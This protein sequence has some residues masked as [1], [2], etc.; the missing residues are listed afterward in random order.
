MKRIASFLIAALMICTVIP[1]AVIPAAAEEEAQP[2]FYEFL[3]VGVGAYIDTGFKPNE[4]TKVVM[5]VMVRG[6]IEYWFGAW[7]IDYRHSAFALGNDSG[8]VYCGYGNQGG[9]EGSLVSPGRH[10]VELGGFCFKLDNANVRPFSSEH[11]SLNSTLYLFAQNRNGQV[12]LRGNEK[13]GIRFYSCQIFDAGLLVRDF[14]PATKVNEAGVL[15]VGVYD[16]ENEVFYAGKGD[17]A[18][19]VY[20]SATL[21]SGLPSG[22]QNEGVLLD[23]DGKI[24]VSKDTTI[25]ALPA[26]SGILIG[27]GKKVTIEVK[28]GVTL[29]VNG[30]NASGRYGGGAGI[31]VPASSTLEIIGNGTLNVKGGNAAVGA[32]GENGKGGTD[33]IQAL[34]FS[35]GQLYSGAGGNGGYG[36]GGAGAGIGGRGGFGGAG[37]AGAVGLTVDAKTSTACTNGI[38]GENGKNGIAGTKGGKITVADTL[39]GT[40][41]GGTTLSIPSQ[42]GYPGQRQASYYTGGTFWYCAC[43]GGGGGAGGNGFA[44]AGIGSGGAGAGGGAGGGSGLTT[45][46]DDLTNVNLVVGTGHGGEGGIGAVNGVNGY[47]HGL[48]VNT[49]DNVAG[50]GGKA[51]AAGGGKGDGDN[52]V[53]LDEATRKETQSLFLDV[54]AGAYIDTGYVPTEKTRIVFDAELNNEMAAVFGVI[55]NADKAQNYYVNSG[56]TTF[57]FGFGSNDA[58]W[59][60]ISILPGHHTIEF[61]DY[62]LKYG[63]SKDEHKASAFSLNGLS[64]YLFGIH[65]DD[66]VQTFEEQHIRCYSCK[67]YEGNKLVRDYIPATYEDRIVFF[68]QQN[69]MIYE[70]QG[71]IPFGIGRIVSPES[72]LPDG[73]TNKGVLIDF[74]GTITVSKNTTINAF[75]MQNGISIADGR[76]VTIE[77]KEGVTLTVKGGDGVDRIGAGAGIEVPENA[78]LTITG[79][80][81]LNATGGNAAA[82]GKGENGEA[83]RL[84]YFDPAHDGTSWLY[85]GAGGKGGNGGGGAGAGIGSKGGNGGLGGNGAAGVDRKETGFYIAYASGLNGENGKNGFTAK[86]Y[87][88]ITVHNSVKK[89]V[90]GGDA[91]KDASDGGNGGNKC[92]QPESTLW[93]WAFGGG[94]GGAGGNGYPAADIGTGGAG[95]GGGAGGGSG[96]IT[97]YNILTNNKPQGTGHGGKGGV[98]AV[99]GKPGADNGDDRD[100]EELVAGAGGEGGLAGGGLTTIGIWEAEQLTELAQAVAN[101]TDYAGVCFRLA[102]DITYNGQPIGS[103]GHPFKGIFDGDGYT[104]TVNISKTDTGAGLFAE[105]DGATIKNLEIKGTVSGKDCVGG[106]VGHAYGNTLIDNCHV[107]ASVTGTAVNIGGV[108]GMLFDS[109]VSNCRVD[110]TVEST[111]SKVGYAGGIVGWLHNNSK[112]VNCVKTGKTSGYKAVGGIVGGAS[113]GDSVI[114]NCTSIGNIKGDNDIGGIIGSI[115]D[116]I[117]TIRLYT[118]Y[119]DCLLDSTHARG[120]ICGYNHN[121][122]DEKV[123]GQPNTLTVEGAQLYYFK[124]KSSYDYTGQ[125]PPPSKPLTTDNVSEALSS[126]NTYVNDHVDIVPN[127]P[128]TKWVQAGNDIFPESCKGFTISYDPQNGTPGTGSIL[129][130]GSLWVV[131]GVILAGITAV[132]GIVV[133]QKKKKP[134]TAASASESDE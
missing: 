27:E 84:G 130:S 125:N 116:N 45:Y 113:E 76:N 15:E 65:I 34:V 101:G 62:A 19:V 103:A 40:I 128:L 50:A 86:S 109:T 44:G 82:G 131:I 38:P 8:G 31:E 111:G 11:F 102:N 74:D 55:R 21:Q 124:Q 6:D 105:T 20:Q 94:G 48:E 39:K 32:N 56:G 91:S 88:R 59:S 79:K 73:V 92:F 110:A 75:P 83:G 72:G 4:N 67:I 98:G 100:L 106:V 89:T 33:N 104:L 123:E 35:V 119:A 126:I 112:V 90:N 42:G 30:G 51:G 95:A 81:T 1:F 118:C 78:S 14:V 53:Y 25:N 60:P 129:S 64:M 70:S 107:T 10:K 23:F 77:I 85:S 57:G 3:D 127:V 47:D 9:T 16:R 5:E 43:G 37:G 52:I 97:Y 58:S 24:T 66:W 87:G 12:G 115:D 134:V 54:E 69:G 63:E 18:M 46:W 71:S 61:A 117:H 36:G 7:D 22:I 133:Y 120:Y 28:D 93:Y 17:S 13:N 80:G 68:D 49:E 114:A 41:Q 2:T 29:T 96:A 121:S 26:Q 132:V 108:V 99:N 122:R